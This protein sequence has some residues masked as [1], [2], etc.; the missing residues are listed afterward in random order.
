MKAILIKGGK[1]SAEDLYIGEEGT[2][3][4]KS[5]EVQIKASGSLDT[6]R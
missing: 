5:H 3:E 2:P 1:G 4:P 6:R